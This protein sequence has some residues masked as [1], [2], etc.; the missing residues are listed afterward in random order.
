MIAHHLELLA[1]TADHVCS[2]T[3][4]SKRQL[5][6]WDATDFFSPT[7]ADDEFGRRA[8]GRVYSFRDL[9]GLRTIAVL[10]EQIPLQELRR[11]GQWLRAHSETPW[12][13]LRLG[14]SGKTVTFQDPAT[15]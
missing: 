4:L 5:R 6:Y 1:F 13:S 10:R 14:V 3:G 12:S 8:F 7:L 15:G 2:L 9:V 11:V